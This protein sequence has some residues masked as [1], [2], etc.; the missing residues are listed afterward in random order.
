MHLVVPCF[1]TVV[2]ISGFVREKT[3]VSRMI[4]VF[5]YVNNAELIA[6]E[7]LGLNWNIRVNS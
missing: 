5:M 6:V 7:N 3:R 1:L 2:I 4:T